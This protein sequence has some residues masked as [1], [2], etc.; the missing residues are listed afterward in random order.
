MALNGGDRFKPTQAV[1]Y[2][3]YCNNDE[4]MIERLYE[5][6]QDGGQVMIPLGRY[7]WS[8]RYAWVQDKYG[9]GWQLDIDPINHALKVVPA[10]LFCDEKRSL[11]KEAM[12]YYNSVFRK[13]RQIMT[14]P[15]PSGSGMP[16]GSLLFTQ[17]QLDDLI[18]NAMS[19][20]TEQ[21]GF[22]FTEGNSFVVECDNQEEIDHYWNLFAAGGKESRCGWIQDK[23]GVWWQVIP[24]VLGELMNNPETSQGV[25]QALLKMGKPDLE[26]LMKAA[27]PST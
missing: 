25:G 6:L 14:Y 15:F 19:G 17:F 21:H 16:D 3:I 9:I 4:P 10:L 22:D 20:G 18:F 27:K 2:F 26:Q 24:A 13:S 23:F 5:Q 8:R 12:E 1:S 11:V 7:D